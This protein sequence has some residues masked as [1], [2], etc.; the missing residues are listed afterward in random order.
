MIKT[1]LILGAK[2]RFGRSATTAFAAAGW[3]VRAASRRGDAQAGPQIRAVAVDARDRAAVIAAAKGAD[4]IVH[5][6]H[7]PYTDWAAELPTLTGNVIAAGLAS[8]ATVMIPG[9]LYN[10]GPQAGA[11]LRE[12]A[13]QPPV[14]RKGALR[15]QMEQ[16]FA[17]ASARGLRTVI[18]RGGDYIEGVKTGNWFEDHITPKAHRGIF[19][20]PGRMD[21]VHAWAYLPD[22]ARAMAALADRRADLPPF[23]AIG[24]EGYSLTG[25]ELMQA[26]SEAVGRPLKRKR[27]PWAVLRVMALASPLM[28]EVI[29]MR[30]LR[31]TP[32]RIDPAPLRAVLPDFAPTPL[33]QA[34]AQML[35]QV[36]DAM[37][38]A[39]RMA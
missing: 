14:T 39:P 32:H 28:R 23:A 13:A 20:Y 24:F 22:M 2:G 34:M 29:E 9:N 25:A 11:V 5:A 17:E 27:F 1:V 30:Y 26:V 35:G 15:V 37:T 10:F 8:G 21:A 3:Q 33:A 18:L 31:D 4:V 16:N 6:L 7:P 19:S 12:G 38:A 36:P